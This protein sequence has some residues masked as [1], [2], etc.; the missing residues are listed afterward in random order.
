MNIILGASGQIGSSIV[1]H[2]LQ[3]RIP[4]KGIVRTTEK[5]KALMAK[6]ADAS[7]ADNFDLPSLKNAFKDGTVVFLITP[8]TESSQDVLGDAKT[9]L[10]NYKT[11]IASSD[12]KKIVALSS[13]GAQYNSGTGNLLMSYM[14]EHAF[15]DLPVQQVFIRPAYYYSN[16]LPYLPLAKEKGI[17]PTY[18]PP[19]L[20]LPMSSPLDIAAFAADVIAQAEDDQHIY[21]VEGPDYYSANDVAEIVGR[22]LHKSIKPEQ[23][24]PSDWKGSLKKIG[25]TDDAADNFIDMTNAVINGKALPESDNPIKVKT[26]LETYLQEH[27]K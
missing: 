20:Q 15:T 10:S 18:F 24:P 4:V 27:I 2:L 5:A 11:A 17:L 13:I 23:I 26:T 14:L 16:L 6:G 19:D 12:I 22:L 25:F 8:E 7:V 1:D 9:I 3:K 21:E